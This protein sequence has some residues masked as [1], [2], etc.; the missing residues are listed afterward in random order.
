MKK[1]NKSR[2][3]ARKISGEITVFLT[4]VFLILLS[5]VAVMIQSARLY[6]ADLFAEMSLQNAVN[7]QLTR[8][9]RPLWEDYHLYMIEGTGADKEQF[10][11]QMRQY[12]GKI[13]TLYYQLE[14]NKFSIED[15]TYFTNYEGSLYQHQIYEYMKYH[16]VPD[17]AKEDEKSLEYAKQAEKTKEVVEKNTEVKQK[18]GEMDK[19]VLILMRLIEGIEI[20]GGKIH[21][22]PYFVKMLGGEGLSMADAGISREEVWDAVKGRYIA[23]ETAGR[24]I[25]KK[26]EGK[27]RQALKVL[28]EMKVIR[29][30]LEEKVKEYEAYY[31]RSREEILKEAAGALDQELEAMKQYTGQRGDDYFQLAVMEQVLQRDLEILTQIGE[32]KADKEDSRKLLEDYEIRS[33]QFHYDSLQLSK[34]GKETVKDIGAALSGGLLE[35]AV[36]DMERISKKA[37][38]GTKAYV[39]RPDG[40]SLI[41]QAMEIA[42][43]ES[44]FKSYKDVSDGV[45]KNEI[46]DSAWEYELE[47]IAA[48]G[49]SDREALSGVVGKIVAIRTGTNIA[50]LLTDSEKCSQAYAMAVAIVGL[51]G[52]EPLIE[53]VKMSILLAWAGEEAVVD[54]ALLLAGKKV[55]V[56]KDAGAF[57]I[58][59][60]ELFSFNRGCV[61]AKVKQAG[62]ESGGLSYTDYLHMFLLQTGVKNR[63]N[64]SL[65]TVEKNMHYRYY[66]DFSFIN[67]IFGI[68]AVGE[69]RFSGGLEVK[70]SISQCY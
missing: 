23:K 69:Y 51:T 19:S 49:K 35:L 30:R 40:G 13:D 67:G 60:G 47:Y 26:V 33:L 54:A 7:S 12:Q 32:G 22:E 9:C 53:A 41:Q 66:D 17:I 58:S 15:I 20:R 63:L 42:Y 28:E 46:E 29:G 50:Y 25:C 65:Y 61:Q 18:L 5:L 48:G 8:Y 57:H 59:F 24:S 10:A 3:I 62:K 68:K 52:M 44:H 45:I 4:F 43:Y 55:P 34:G 31:K 11:K 14:K 56:W 1:G 21:T 6:S 37:I 27:L 2:E 36:E 16:L 70:K 39:S 38:T 64:R